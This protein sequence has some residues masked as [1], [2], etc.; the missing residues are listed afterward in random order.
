MSNQFSSYDVPSYLRENAGA[1]GDA[2]MQGN[3]SNNFSAPQGE[4]RMVAVDVEQFVRTRDALSSAYMSLSSSID[5][6]VKAYIDHTNV[7]LAGD[8][9][10]NMSYLQQPFDQL[11]HA[12]HIAQQAFNLAS[13]QGNGVSAAS[14]AGASGAEEPRKKRPYKP[15]DPNAPKRPLTAYFRYLQE[16][17]GPLGEEMKQAAGGVPQKPGDLSKEA[18]ERWNKL[19]KQEQQPYRD[20]Y[21]HALKD[22]EREVKKYKAEKNGGQQEEGAE[23]E[24][25]DDD[26][27]G[28]GQSAR[29]GEVDAAHTKDEQD[30]DDDDESSDEESSED[31]E[32]AP[33]PPP[34]PMK[35]KT[36]KSKKN[37][38][39]APPTPAA[40]SNID[41]VLTAQS[42]QQASSSPSKKRKTADETGE[43]GKKSKKGRKT[44]TAGAET[45][46][47]APVAQMQ[48]EA[49]DT[50]KKKKKK[51]KGGDSS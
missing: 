5:K 21:Q 34:P 2:F 16:M 48:P 46:A 8:A 32:P 25:D 17:R 20:A 10:L 47:P 13:G 23:D 24:D 15:R 4:K 33:P 42:Q 31:D 6:A 38:N 28:E 43:S 9:S 7:I 27:D 3:G 35:E 18:T 40:D 49:P 26:E 41:P 36:P 19:S 39:A 29:D 12:S 30:S 37:K 45:P 51:K 22:Y 1:G 14:G 44:A 50:E 11:A